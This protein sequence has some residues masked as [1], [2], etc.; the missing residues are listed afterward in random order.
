MRHHSLLVR[1]LIW[2]AKHLSTRQFVIIL[3]ILIGLLS[4]LA[5]A[6]L[7][8]LVYQLKSFLADL[9]SQFVFDYYYLA[10]PFVGIVLAVLF[11]RYLNRNKLGFGIPNMLYTIT[12]KAGLF[13]R[14]KMYS[15]IVTSSLTVGFGGSVGLEAPIVMTGAAYG[16]NIA[17]L[18]HLDYKRRILLLGCG[19]AGALSAVFAAPIAAV[20]FVFE[21]LLLDIGVSYLIPLLLASVS[22]MIIGDVLST[23][24]VIIAYSGNYEFNLREV[25]LYI[26]LGVL[27]GLFSL[28]FNKTY[29][30][31]E[32]L[33]QRFRQ[34]LPKAVLGGVVLGVLIFIFPPLYG[35]G[36]DVIRVLLRDQPEELFSRSIFGALEGGFW[37][38]PVFILAVML[39]KVVATSV[40]ISAGGNGGVFAPS[41]FIGGLLGFLF[42]RSCNMMGWPYP[43]LES[44][45][46]LV[47]MA[48]LMSGLMHAPLTG[49]FLIAEVTSGYALFVPLMIVSAI[50]YLTTIIFEPHSF[51]TKKL[52]EKGELITRDKD[53][54]V[55]RLLSIKRVVEHDLPTIHPQATLG[56]LVDMVKHA[57][58]NIFP[59]VDE[60]QRLRGIVLLDDIRE[61]MFKPELY[62]SVKVSDLMHS[63]P[64][65]VDIQDSMDVVM[66]KFS[67]TGAWNLPV[68]R[69]E[70]YEGFV[71]KSKIFSVY[72]TLLIN[73]TSD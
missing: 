42:A 25:P 65:Y 55:L 43:L 15:H 11:V 22:G 36:Y 40:T 28:L 54:L 33:F 35:E 18:F 4:G 12:R 16:S 39:V 26:I 61:V 30:G 50:S 64:G 51:N 56:D 3:S 71:S 31:I 23:A 63:P 47:A 41:L 7:K 34:R 17:Q 10:F 59:V 8:T 1:F 21:V 53:K 46:A 29:F 44:S 57:H 62:E 66:K 38:I 32:K 69:G 68:L 27:T 20:I 45:F 37:Q 48:G 9:D 70:K 72:R 58:R 52:A 60:E 24:E 14:D 13:E 49:I 5:A 6:L 67:D 73:Q 19:V 2:R